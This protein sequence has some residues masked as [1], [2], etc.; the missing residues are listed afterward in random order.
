MLKWGATERESAM[1][2]TEFGGSDEKEEEVVG[3]VLLVTRVHVR[4]MRRDDVVSAIRDS[5]GFIATT[6]GTPTTSMSTAKRNH[7][8]AS[9]KSKKKKMSAPPP[10]LMEEAVYFGGLGGGDGDEVLVNALKHVVMKN[11]LYY[12]NHGGEILHQRLCVVDSVRVQDDDAMRTTLVTETVD[13]DGDDDDR[14]G[15]GHGHGHGLPI[16]VVMEAVVSVNERATCGDAAKALRD[17]MCAQLDAALKLIDAQEEKGKMEMLTTKTTAVKVKIFH[18]ATRDGSFYASARCVDDEDNEMDEMSDGAIQRRLEEQREYC[19]STDRPLVRVHQALRF[20]EQHDHQYADGPSVELKLRGLVKPAPLLV[21]VHDGLAPS[22]VE[23]GKVSTVHGFYSY[24]HYMQDN[25]DDKGWGCAYRSLQ[26]IISW[27]KM[28]GHIAIEDAA[29]DTSAASSSRFVPS[30][31]DV[32]SVLVEMGDKPRSF[33]RS[34]EW[35]GAIELGMVIDELYSVSYKVLNMPSGRDLS[36]KG[37]EL[38][39]HFEEQGTPIMV[40]GGALAYTMLGID[41]NENTGD[42]AFLILDPHYVGAEDVRTIQKHKWCGWRRGPTH[43]SLGD[44][45]DADSFY[46]LMMPQRPHTL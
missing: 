9:S 22:G 43:D 41:Y 40:G 19:V 42:I 32:Q 3:E 10:G 11:E 17:E 5:C 29:Q 12:M 31:T 35:I 45:F 15:Y 7:A 2:M 26:T 30:H 25:F 21:N 16:E 14:H 27:L 8:E 20:F 1:V 13:D 38:R 24:H 34:R 44:I 33:V 23:G 18:F 39:A 46:N 28:Q 37:R 36:T 4:F 6:R